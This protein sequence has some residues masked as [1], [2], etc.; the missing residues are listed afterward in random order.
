LIVTLFRAA[1]DLRAW[2]YHTIQGLHVSDK[3]EIDDETC[4]ARALLPQ[5]MDEDGCGA[6]SQKLLH[7]A[8]RE[9]FSYERGIPVGIRVTRVACRG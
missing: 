8:A 2:L 3:E 6:R 9:A 1:A 5:L 7:A 4:R